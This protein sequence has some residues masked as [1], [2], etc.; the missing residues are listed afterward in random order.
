MMPRAAKA[1]TILFAASPMAIAAMRSDY[2]DPIADRW[3]DAALSDQ[4]RNGRLVTLEVMTRDMAVADASES[5]TEE[6]GV[7]LCVFDAAATRRSVDFTTELL[8]SAGLP[9]VCIV[10]DPA[11]WRQFQHGGIIFESNRVEPATLAAM[12]Y[13][14]GQRQQ[15][16]SELRR[17]MDVTQRCESTVRNELER[18]HEELQLAASVQR[19][20]VSAP[21]PKADRL[22]YAMLYRPVN[23]VSGDVCCVR[24]AGG[25]VVEF[26]LA[27]AAGHGVPAAL[28]TMVLM[29]SLH[30]ISSR[31]HRTL[32]PKE[33]LAWL[34]ECVCR[35]CQHFGW[36]AT[37]VY[38]LLDTRTGEGVLAGAG[39]PPPLMLGVRGKER[40]ELMTMGPVLGVAEDAQFT[41]ERFR[42]EPGQPLLVYS[43]GL[44][45]AFP[46]ASDSEPSLEMRERPHLRYLHELDQELETCASQPGGESVL[47]AR[48]IT[49]RLQGMVDLQVGSLHQADDITAMILRCVPPGAQSLRSNPDWAYGEA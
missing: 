4:I 30:T 9:A 32:D 48:H 23:F 35:H 10:P 19:E 21:A 5:V 18:M 7:V 43:D 33:V 36:F 42:L 39:H 17:E 27:D 8:R 45:C 2:I 12:L 41:D 1:P 14:L 46:G 11:P 15:T 49:R 38:G 24:D 26:F 44:E 20:F 3:P 34:N 25:D 22:D 6:A 37:A 13:A 47:E 40:R 29:H 31:Q 28:L 16:V